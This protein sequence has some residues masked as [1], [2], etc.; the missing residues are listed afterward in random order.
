M[1]VEREGGLRG[2]ARR[3]PRMLAEWACEPTRRRA[4]GDGAIGFA[5]HPL[6]A[7]FAVSAD[8]LPTA[9]GLAEVA[10]AHLEA[11]AAERR[12]HAEARRRRQHV[13][14]QRGRT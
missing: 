1:R 12:T 13:K 6:D 3:Q 11:E 14:R 10:G 2:G 8:E 5:A 7:R 4:D 9:L